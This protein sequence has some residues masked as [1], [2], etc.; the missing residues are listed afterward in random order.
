[1]PMQRH[2]TLVS[3][4]AVIPAANRRET[5]YHI[6]ISGYSSQDP[7]IFVTDRVRR[8][9][10]LQWQGA[11]AGRLLEST[12]LPLASMK[13][14]RH[15][16][17]KPLMQR[18]AMAGAAATSSLADGRRRK[19]ESRTG[20]CTE[21]AVVTSESTTR[22]QAVLHGCVVRLLEDFPKQHL[23]EEDIVC[24]MQFRMP[25][26][27]GTQVKMALDDL[28]AWKRIQRITVQGGSAH[29]DLDTRPH[30]HIYDARTRELRDAPGSGVL[31]VS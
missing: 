2:L 22:R 13:N 15:D 23:A 19:V 20:S 7:L 29:Y 4:Q 5:R 18:L 28:A 26:V 27:S 6:D 17:D 9:T 24:L 3:R 10:I 14:G 8:R 31:R 21:H 1:M 25:C 30:L 11:I 12:A 16:C